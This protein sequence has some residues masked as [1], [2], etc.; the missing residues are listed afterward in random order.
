[1]RDACD[2]PGPRK[3]PAATRW[4]GAS[5][6]PEKQRKKKLANPKYGPETV[7]GGWVLLR[8]GVSLESGFVGGKLSGLGPYLVKGLQM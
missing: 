3:K 7:R 4:A 8:P 1:M 2:L 5:T 6:A